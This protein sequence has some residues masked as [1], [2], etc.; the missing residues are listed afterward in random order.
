MNSKRNTVIYWLA[1]ALVAFGFAAGGIAD[2]AEAPDMVAAMTHL[3]YPAYFATILGA[4]K[5]LGAIA[6]VVPGMPRLKEW[7]YAGMVFDLT[8]AVASHLA[9][10]DGVGQAIAPVVLLAFV[11]VSW[12]MRP[13]SRTLVAA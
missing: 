7:A 4:W 13:R 6:I 11:A 3:G 10:G 5:L 2:L 8:G 9:S 1:T 12:A